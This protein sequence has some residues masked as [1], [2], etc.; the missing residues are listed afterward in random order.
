MTIIYENQGNLDAQRACGPDSSNPATQ[1][2]ICDS[3]LVAS[4][5]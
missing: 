1:V 4:C 2:G 3:Q 5:H